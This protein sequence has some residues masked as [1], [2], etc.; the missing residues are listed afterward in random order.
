VVRALKADLD[1]VGAHL[2]GARAILEDCASGVITRSQAIDRARELE[3]LPIATATE[4]KAVVV[5][6]LVSGDHDTSLGGILRA[7]VMARVDSQLRAKVQLAVKGESPDE[8]VKISAHL[9]KVCDP[10]QL[11][12]IADGLLEYGK[13]GLTSSMK[14]SRRRRRSTRE[15][16][17]EEL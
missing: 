5:R 11:G 17:S 14:T 12:R 13:T 7:I 8:A 6:G 10:V 2:P 15:L 9:G 3:R 1:G 4:L 16:L